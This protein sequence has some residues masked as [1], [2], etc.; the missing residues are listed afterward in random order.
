MEI[1]KDIKEYE[2]LYLVSNYGKVKSKRKQRKPRLDKYGYPTV[3]LSKNGIKKHYKIH[4]LV[5]IAFLPN[6]YNKPTVNH[7]DG[8]KENNHVSNLEWNTVKENIIHASNT[9]L[10]NYNGSGNPNVK[11]TPQ[12]VLAIKSVDYSL[13]SQ[14]R[15]SRI[16]GVGTT[17][18]NRIVRNLC[19]AS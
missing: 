9:D 15:I 19:W 11:L 18:I 16:Y 5:A 7:K 12:E 1:W 13:I 2:G 8:N 3:S 4:R 10:R 6:E 14:A 17:Q